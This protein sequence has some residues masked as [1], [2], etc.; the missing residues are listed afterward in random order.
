[1]TAR[2]IRRIVERRLAVAAG[3][4][5]IGAPGQQRADHCRP[6]LVGRDDEGGLAVVVPTI[7]VGSGFDQGDGDSRLRA[8][9]SKVQWIEMHRTVFRLDSMSGPPRAVG[10]GAGLD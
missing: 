4:I 8:R 9:E 3:S 7:G 6:V 10:I 1:M 2:P 5:W